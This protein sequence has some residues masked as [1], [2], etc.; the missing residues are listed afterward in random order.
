MVPHIGHRDG[1][2]AISNA[3][4][5]SALSEASVQGA[6]IV[7]KNSTGPPQIGALT[8]ALSGCAE[9]VME[10]LLTQGFDRSQE[11]KADLYAANLLKRAGYDP[12]ALKEALSI[13][14]NQGNARA[15]VGSPPIRIPQ[16]GLRS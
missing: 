3:A 1:V 9:G 7:A 15:W 4:L 14:A 16:I 5:L 11:Y 6:S 2:N 8:E 12:A 13:L 10:R